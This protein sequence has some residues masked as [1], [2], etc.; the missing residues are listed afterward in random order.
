MF[1]YSKT[2]KVLI[3]VEKSEL[4]KALFSLK[5]SP[6]HLSWERVM[7]KAPFRLALAK[8]NHLAKIKERS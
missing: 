7:L 1:L 5:K 6:A 2:S 4:Q 8:V 3:Y